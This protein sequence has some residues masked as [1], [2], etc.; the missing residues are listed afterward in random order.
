MV[1]MTLMVFIES[2]VPIKI[3][4]RYVKRKNAVTHIANLPSQDSLWTM[5]EMLHPLILCRYKG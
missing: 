4:R 3:S 5:T 2:L 1:L